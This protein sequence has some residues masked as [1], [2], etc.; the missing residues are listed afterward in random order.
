MNALLHQRVIHVWTAE[1]EESSWN[2]IEVGTVTDMVEDEDDDGDDCQMWEVTFDGDDNESE[3]WTPERVRIGIELCERS[4]AL[5]DPERNLLHERVA[6]EVCIGRNREIVFGRVNG[7]SGNLWTVKCDLQHL[8]H[9]PLHS[10]DVEEG[11]RRF[12]DLKEFAKEECRQIELFG[13]RHHMGG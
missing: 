13:R 12:R 6:L 9:G 2:I 3:C 8:K 4:I 1:N 7:R 11:I 5:R 10:V